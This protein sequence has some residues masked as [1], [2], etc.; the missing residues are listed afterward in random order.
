MTQVKRGL[1]NL[2]TDEK[3]RKMVKDIIDFYATERDEEIGVIAA[4]ALLDFMLDAIGRDLYN[5]GV[6]DTFQFIKDRLLASETDM[7]ALIKK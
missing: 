5:K 4:G 6:D 1:E 3:R 7:N 2:L